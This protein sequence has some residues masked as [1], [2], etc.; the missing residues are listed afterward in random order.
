M[1]EHVV[2]GPIIVQVWPSKYTLLIF[3]VFLSRILWYICMC[4]LFYQLLY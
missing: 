3:L 1:T 4:M 2:L